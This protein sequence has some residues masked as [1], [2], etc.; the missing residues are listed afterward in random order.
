[1]IDGL[2]LDGGFSAYVLDGISSSSWWAA[3]RHPIRW[4][5]REGMGMARGAD[6][7][8]SG[9]VRR[10]CSVASLGLGAVAGKSPNQASS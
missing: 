10:P 7:L 1:M 4:G 8:V 2:A 5:I 3:G 9:L 6:R